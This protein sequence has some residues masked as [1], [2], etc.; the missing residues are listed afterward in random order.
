MFEVYHKTKQKGHTRFILR[1]EEPGRHLVTYEDVSSVDIL[2]TRRLCGMWPA[3][4]GERSSHWSTTLVDGG[5]RPC[6][7]RRA[8]QSREKK[9]RFRWQLFLVGTFD[10]SHGNGGCP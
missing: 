5:E 6:H 8:F 10:V 2:A 7:Q 9:K 3:G 4:F 1:Q